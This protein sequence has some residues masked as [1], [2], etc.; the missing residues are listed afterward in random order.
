MFRRSHRGQDT[1]S[2]SVCFHVSFSKHLFEG[3]LIKSTVGRWCLGEHMKVSLLCFLLS[4]ATA[5][6]KYQLCHYWAWGPNRCYYTSN[7]F[8]TKRSTALLHLCLYHK[9][10]SFI[11]QFF[12][13]DIVQ[14]QKTQAIWHL[15]LPVQTVA[16]LTTHDKVLAFGWGYTP[17]N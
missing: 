13:T 16:G 7:Y 1:K 8:F 14:I 5:R 9:T 2:G 10:Y 4:R 12:A 6:H 15:S 17:V 3:E 11:R